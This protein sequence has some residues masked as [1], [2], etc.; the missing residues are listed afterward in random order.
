MIYTIMCKTIHWPT[1]AHSNWIVLIV[2]TSHFR[3]LFKINY[4]LLLWWPGINIVW[5]KKFQTINNPSHTICEQIADI[6]GG[7]Y[8]KSELFRRGVQQPQRAAESES[9][10]N[11]R[12]Q[13][14]Q[15]SGEAEEKQRL[16]SVWGIF[17]TG[18]ILLWWLRSILVIG[19]FPLA[20]GKSKLFG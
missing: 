9:R 4:I 6:S 19:K 13:E 2:F 15:R 1:V 17:T 20:L 12:S 7:D 3:Q 10:Q 16:I 5:N 18:T 14:L 11:C 8:K